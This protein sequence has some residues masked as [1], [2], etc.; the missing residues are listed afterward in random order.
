MAQKRKTN[1]RK[2]VKR[3]WFPI[4]SP[5]LFGSK[6]VG[7]S[8]TIDYETKVGKT[9]DLN[10][11][12]ATGNMRQQN[13]NYT[14]EIVK[15]ENQELRTI[16]KGAN[17][18]NSYVKRIVR[19]NS[20]RVDDS[21]VIKTKDNKYV[22]IKPILLTRFNIVDSTQRL[23][24]LGFKQKILMIGLE[25]TYDELTR[26]IYKSELQKRIVK[27]LSN[28]SSIKFF[29]IRQYELLTKYIEGK[30]EF[31]LEEIKKLVELTTT[32][33]VKIQ[34]AKEEVAKQENT[35]EQN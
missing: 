35:T 27:E 28:V 17:L 13:M 23:L 24:R 8:Y 1:E 4:I 30:T 3:K 21:F 10:G 2:T 26:I 9:V 31:D 15:A 19:K 32:E 5:E 6:E 7:D 12:F 29:E 25:S 34:K 20:S 22:R 16:I 18:L 11:M 33:K 14:L